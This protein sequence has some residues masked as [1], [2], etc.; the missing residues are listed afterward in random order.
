MAVYFEPRR[1]PWYEG[2]L[3]MLAGTVLN[4]ALQRTEKAKEFEYEKRLLAEEEARK[5]RAMAY[6][7]QLRAE[8][9]ARKIAEAQR[10]ENV[11]RGFIDMLREGLNNHPYG[12]PGI[13]DV[14]GGAIGAGANL[15]ALQNYVLPKQ[16]ELDLGGQ[17][18]A[19]AV[20]PN[21]QGGE[22]RRYNVTMTPQQIGM[23]DLA[24]RELALK[25][26]KAQQDASQG[27]ASLNNARR[28]SYSLNGDYVDANGNP[29]LIDS[30]SGSFKPLPGI[31][32]RPNAL[33]QTS[34]DPVT[35][36]KQASE[37]YKNL[38][39]TYP[40]PENT[41]QLDAIYKYILSNLGIGGQQGGQP[42]AAP[43]QF[44]D[45][46]MPV[47]T[48]T[49]GGQNIPAEVALYMKYRPGITPEQ[50][51]KEINEVKARKRKSQSTGKSQGW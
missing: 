25:N 35:R 2:P 14:V 32:K 15:E 1:E 22:E 29:V 39:G 18:V 9:E 24:K 43:G 3:T 7:Q 48:L 42:P 27:W 38:L 34:V 40:D 31:V 51:Q 41:K 16:Q 21:G 33:A 36:A 45:I 13:A 30:R 17:K 10:Q 26:W 5:Q 20:F 47:D 19:R 6:E 23:M 11:K 50:A 44:N 37:I 8:E 46:D 4:G 28:P 12:L 49:L